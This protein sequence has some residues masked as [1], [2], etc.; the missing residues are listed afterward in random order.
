MSPQKGLTEKRLKELIGEWQE[1]FMQDFIEP[2]L[3]TKYDQMRNSIQK[4]VDVLRPISVVPKQ[5]L[6]TLGDSPGPTIEK[7]ND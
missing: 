7:L 3:N 2:A 6:L 1:N 4:K 5:E